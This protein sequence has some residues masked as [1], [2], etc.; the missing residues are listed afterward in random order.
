M[1]LVGVLGLGASLCLLSGSATAQTRPASSEPWTLAGPHFVVSA[2]RLSAFL[3]WNSHDDRA[4]DGSVDSSSASGT[5]LALLGSGS[6][7]HTVLGSPRLGF[8][9]ELALGVTL[10]VAL[11]YV[12]ASRSGS[13]FSP[14]TTTT[15]LIAAPRVGVLLIPTAR[16]AIW[17]RG[18]LTATHSTSS[19][20]QPYVSGGLGLDGDSSSTLWDVTLDPQLLLVAAPH[21][22][23]SV[24]VV[25]D[26]GAAGS[27]TL[28][29]LN[30][31]SYGKRESAYGMSIGLS[32]IF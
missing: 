15:A 10:G 22:A 27:V 9:A 5:D 32:A 3:A 23:F 18:G 26:I 16:I 19:F 20:E 14:K 12:H 6:A 11:G 30:G 28:G 13:E 7:S 31:E 25:A 24:G 2:E 21:V 8:D 1:K 29:G 4:S 17:L